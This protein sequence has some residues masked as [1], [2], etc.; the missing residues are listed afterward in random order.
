METIFLQIFEDISEKALYTMLMVVDVQE[1]FMIWEI[2]WYR[3]LND[4]LLKVVIK[5]EM[6]E[7]IARKI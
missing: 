6:V 4:V 3:I 2:F 7:E 1:E 5:K